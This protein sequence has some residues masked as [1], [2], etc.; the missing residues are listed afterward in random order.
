MTIITADFPDLDWVLLRQTWALAL[1]GAK[2]LRVARAGS[3]LSA[4][5]KYLPLYEDIVT[6]C[7]ASGLG[8]FSAAGEDIIFH[9]GSCKEYQLEVE[10]G[11]FSSFVEMVL[12]LTPWCYRRTFRTV[13]HCRGVSHCGLSRPTSFIRESLNDYSEQMGLYSSMLLQRFGFY[14]SGGGSA[15][16]RI[17]PAEARKIQS[18][19][20]LKD[21]VIAG[22]RIFFAGISPELAKR[23]K[24]R[25]VSLLG[26]S[27]RDVAI[28]EI[29]DADGMGNSLQ[30]SLKDGE[31][32][33]QLDAEMPIYNHTGEVI[34][35]EGDFNCLLEGLCSDAFRA[36]DEKIMPPGM[37]RELL[38]LMALS[39][40]SDL[41]SDVVTSGHISAGAAEIF[42]SLQDR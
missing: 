5:P 32:V 30:V 2:P 14:G 12:F 21:P 13:I 17:Y 33:I 4:Y 37:A 39:G 19:F 41:F 29:R 23:Q 11:R 9:P 27:E 35:D 15:E 26:L 25:M 3:F 38:P 10:S 8:E 1:A 42:S 18:P 24:A 7:D 22:A 31:R 34:V 20:L 16:A 6:L 40:N 36:V 28:I